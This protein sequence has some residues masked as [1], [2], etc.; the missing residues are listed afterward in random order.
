MKTD[1]TIK[2]LW[3]VIAVLLGVIVLRPVFETRRAQA[4]AGYAPSVVPLGMEG[5][6]AYL[7]DGHTGDIWM[8][9]SDGRVY[10]KGRLEELGKPLAN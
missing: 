5:N 7:M 10:F 2:I 4:G 9:T 6:A 3:T 1:R 8:Y